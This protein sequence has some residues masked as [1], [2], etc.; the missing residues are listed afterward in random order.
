M[1]VDQ[2]FDFDVLCE[3]IVIFEGNVCEVVCLFLK[4]VNVVVMLFL[5]GFG[6]ECMY[7]KL[8]VDLM[9]DENIYYVEVC[10]VF[11]GFELMMCG[12]LLVVNFKIFVL[13][14]FSV[15]CVLGNCVYVVLI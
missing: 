8:F 14:V 12:K 4:N 3:L 2:Q 6:F 11:G 15:V 7:V 5:V 13:M 10:G 1:L 9:V